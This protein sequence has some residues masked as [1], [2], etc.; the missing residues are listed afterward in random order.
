[1]LY[2]SYPFV[3]S[4]AGADKTMLEDSESKDRPSVGIGSRWEI[5]LGAESVEN[6]GGLP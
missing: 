5:M 4:A 2:I 6:G 1:M 3:K